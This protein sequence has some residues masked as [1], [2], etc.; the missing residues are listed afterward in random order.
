MQKIQRMAVA[1]GLGLT[2][3]LLPG[4]QQAAPET[5]STKQRLDELDKLAA[6]G[7]I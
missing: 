3:T 6:G 2:T 7:Y 1:L 5:N 4:A